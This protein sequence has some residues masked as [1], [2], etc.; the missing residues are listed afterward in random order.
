MDDE[1]LR[2][3]ADWLTGW[4]D[5]R[6]LD[7]EISGLWTKLRALRAQ[8]AEKRALLLASCPLELTELELRFWTK[9]IIKNDPDA[10]WLWDG[11]RRTTKGEEY[12]IFRL[13]GNGRDS[14]GGVVGAHRVALM[15]TNGGKLPIVGRHTCDTPPCCR[16]KHLLDGTHLD[17]MRDRQE[18][19]RYG[20]KP[21]QR[22][23]A[24]DS[25]VLTDA[26]VLDARRR[27][28][29]GE[30]VTDIAAALGLGRPTLSYAVNGTTWKHLDGIEPPVSRKRR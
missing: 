27:A 15:L 5:I 13:E 17:N 4:G 6:K 1:A 14:N 22:G 20:C 16:P 18:R 7:D 28:R 30:T 11:A 9:V 29:A 24:N 19:G 25:A 2:G 8:R 3:L 26:I 23:E 10:C 21:N 12:G